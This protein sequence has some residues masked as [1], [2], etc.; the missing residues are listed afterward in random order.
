MTDAPGRVSAHPYVCPATGEPLDLVLDA[1]RRPLRLESRNG[2][3][4]PVKDGIAEL[5]SPRRLE[6]PDEA[7]RSFYDGR[8]DDYDRYLPLTFRTH[9]ENELAVRNGF[10]DKLE[11]ALDAKVLEVACGTGRDSELIARRLGP[12]GELFMLDIAHGMLSRCGRRMAP[13]ALARKE[14]AL[15][16][17]VRLP[18]ADRSF[19]AVYSFGGLGEFS[20]IRASLAEMVRVCRVGGRVV[21]GDES[22]PPWLRDTDFARILTTTNPQ[23]AAEVPLDAMPVEA[24]RVR[25]EWVI[26]GVFYLI[27]FSVGEGEPTA[28]FDFEIPGVRG[29]T[30]RTRYEGR[31]EGVTPETK[32]LAHE[33]R[34]RRGVSMHRWLDDVVRQ[35]ALRQLG[36]GDDAPAGASSLGRLFADLAGSHPTRPALRLPEG[37]TI[38]YGRLDA[39]SNQLAR[40]FADAGVARRD[41][42]AI[43]HD[44]GSYA[45]AAILA[46]LKL[47][48]AYVNLDPSSPARRLNR[49]L[50]RCRPKLLLHD[51]S[52]RAALAALGD[53]PDAPDAAVACYDDAGMREEVAALP[54]GPLPDELQTAGPDDAAYIMFTSGSTGFPKGVVITH[55]SV[56]NFIRWSRRTFGIEADDILTGVN[57]AYFDNS[58]FDFYSS[59]FTGASLAPAPDRLLKTPRELLDA[60][61][62]AGC[63]IWFSVPSM[64][65]YLLRMKALRAGHL[66]RLRTVVFGG[67]GFPKRHLRAL[68]ALLGEGVRLVNVYGPTECTCICSW[69]DVNAADLEPPELLPLGEL[70]EGFE[71][72]ILDEAGREVEPDE[73]GE[74]CLL[75]PNVGLGYYRDEEATRRSFVASPADPARTMY[76]TGDM[77]RVDGRTGRLHFAGRKDNQIKHMGFRIELE[78][79]ETAL[80]G[81]GYVEECAVVYVKPDADVGRI[82]AYVTVEGERAESDIIGDL[83]GHLPPYMIPNRIEQVAALPRNRNGKIDRLVLAGA[84]GGV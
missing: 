48:A 61:A 18:F 14:L 56:M 63:T 27:D 38:T 9:G 30:Y 12:E 39:L 20:D 31:L 72:L 65:V 17:A 28:D 41:V 35:E 7:V 21:V 53:A 15:A 64:L 52:S 76:R 82:V 37:A 58:V 23:F 45:Y 55:R 22:M 60:L 70:M 49:I 66:P 8:V 80:G 71:S 73:I 29:G 83:R 47:G 25:L 36:P 77:V 46:A 11:L 59:V 24:R 44:K 5:T 79:I 1:D 81:L 43:F 2:N 19:D 33:A 13:F 62:R 84:G 40:H 67:E 16:N 54:A 32:A 10:I 4:Y 74:L 57:P 75:G 51:A 69:Y 78:E 42:V 3:I 50:S 26:G 68:H 34:A 6:A